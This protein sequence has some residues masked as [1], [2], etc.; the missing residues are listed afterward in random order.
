MT[1]AMLLPRVHHLFAA[2][3]AIGVAVACSDHHHDE[4][5]FDPDCHGGIGGFCDSHHDCESGFCC[6]S[7]N[8][9]GGMCTVPCQGDG[10]CP[11]DMLC[12]HGVCFFACHSNAD[13]AHG[14]SCEHGSVCEWP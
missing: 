13:C 12:E 3:F 10:D 4:C 1:K 5:R 6:E 9:G 7:D 8:C 2:A 11:H 14:M